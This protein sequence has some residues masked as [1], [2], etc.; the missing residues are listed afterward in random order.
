[1]SKTIITTARTANTPAATSESNTPV[2]AVTGKSY[3]GDKAKRLQEEGL[4]RGYGSREWATMK[5][6]NTA[7]QTIA[8][9]E[10][11]TL[12]LFYEQAEGDAGPQ[13]RRVFLFNRCQL[14]SF[15]A[16]QAKQQ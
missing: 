8:K 4:Y 12:V 2:N 10:K 9:G 5:Q 13:A 6:W 14:E 3:F 11:G 7:K 1:M 15:K 16:A